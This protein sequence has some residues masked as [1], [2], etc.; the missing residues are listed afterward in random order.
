MQEDKEL[1][2]VVTTAI[3]YTDDRKFLITK[4][5]PHEVHFPNKWTVPGGRLSTDDYINTPLTHKNQ[6]Y[7]ALTNTLKREV[8]EEVGLE[9]DKTEYLLDL[10]FIKGGGTPVLVL[11]YFAKYLGGEVV[12]GE[13]ATEFAWI[14]TDEIPKYDLIE[15]IGHE[16]K[17]VDEILRNRND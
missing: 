10:T 2:K 6:W 5:A 12:L 8:R 1:H 14:S 15:G 16:L 11:S 3:I 9:I 4:R 7:Y 17:L 13:D